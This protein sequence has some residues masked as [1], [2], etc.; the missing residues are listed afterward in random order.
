M[1]IR[2]LANHAH[3]SPASINPAGT[4][5]R[6]LALMDACGIEQAVGFAPF[7][8]QCDGKD[9]DPNAWLAD[10][11][12]SHDR[13]LGFG[14]IE[15]RK[16]DF[17]DQVARIR[18]LGLRGL[19]LH[20]NAQGFD[21]LSAAAFEVYQAAQDANLFITFHT[22]VHQSHMLR[23]RVINFDEIAW[24]FPDLR[25]SM[26]HVGGYHFFNEALAVIFN[27]LPPPWAPNQKCNVFGGLASI[28][29]Q[30]QNRFWYLGHDRLLE[31]VAQVG[32]AQLIFGLDFPFNLERETQMA[33]D[34][35]NALGLDD[36]E[37]AAVLGENLRRELGLK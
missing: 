23:S 14:T 20:P 11:V 25:F 37:K 15:W 22:G 6:L 28:F 18:D 13:L 10:Q 17:A 5:D 7:P 4:V 36:D 32:A 27:H 16:T 9:I 1:S 29:T 21:I 3:V 24:A 35:I 8:A 34:A 26:E 31:L 2:I 33:F 19:K 30:H 12:R